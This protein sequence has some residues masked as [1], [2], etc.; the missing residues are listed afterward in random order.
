MNPVLAIAVAVGV[1]V[2]A[3]VAGQE[4]KCEAAR[5]ARLAPERSRLIEQCVN[6]EK[7][8]RSFCDNYYRDYGHGGKRGGARVERKYDNLPECVAAREAKPAVTGSSE[9]T[10]SAKSPAK[11]PASDSEKK[12]KQRDSDQGVNRSR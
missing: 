3:D 6:Q 4:A 2:A 12:G 10:S 7:K 5:E 8:E 11:S 1:T 9:R